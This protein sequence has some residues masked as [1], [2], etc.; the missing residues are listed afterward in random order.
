MVLH[1]V[2]SAG[3]WQAAVASVLL[4]ELSSCGNPAVKCSPSHVFLCP[5]SR[6]AGA[7]WPAW[8]RATAASLSSAPP[9]P[10]PAT[11]SPAPWSPGRSHEPKTK[12]F[13][14]LK[15]LASFLLP[16][17]LVPPSGSPT[18]RLP[19][20]S[21]V[22]PSHRLWTLFLLIGQSLQDWRMLAQTKDKDLRGQNTKAKRINRL[23][24]QL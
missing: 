8:S 18:S 19:P 12:D 11:R 5:S 1:R 7:P 2:H 15:P 20:T 6:S 16:F 3:R 23:C 14:P 24:I 10:P 4:I 13:A 22:D 17:F 9:P 21:L